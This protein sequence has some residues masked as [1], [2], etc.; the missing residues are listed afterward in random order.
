M[1]HVTYIVKAQINREIYLRLNYSKANKKLL[2][3]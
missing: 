1:V 2:S 3:C